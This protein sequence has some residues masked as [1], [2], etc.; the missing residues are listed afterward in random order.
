[1]FII[2]KETMGQKTVI[3]QSLAS[4]AVQKHPSL[5]LC[6][7]DLCFYTA[8]KPR[9]LVNNNYMEHNHTIIPYSPK[10]WWGI[11]FGSLAVS[12]A[13]TKLKSANISYSHIYMYVWPSRTKPPNLN[14]PIQ[15]QQRFGAQP[16]NLIPAN[17]SGYT[18]Y[19]AMHAINKYILLHYREGNMGKYSAQE[20]QYWPDRRKGQ[21]RAR[22]LNISPY[23]PTKGSVIIDLFYDW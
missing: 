3:D 6:P 7:R 23:C 16:P 11:K 5:R 1:M 15:L 12:C 21:Y 8:Y 2:S 4:Y 17:I 9:E 18:V 13:T 19:P 20:W 10:F 22:E 14:P